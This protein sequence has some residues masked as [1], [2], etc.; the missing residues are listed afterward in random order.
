MGTALLAS[1]LLAPYGNER[2]IFKDSQKELDTLIKYLKKL[3]AKDDYVRGFEDAR[4]IMIDICLSVKKKLAVGNLYLNLLIERSKH[5]NEFKWTENITII[6]DEF[7]CITLKNGIR[8]AN[9]S[10]AHGYS[11]V[12]EEYLPS[13][14]KEVA[15]KYKM[16]DKHLEKTC[17]SQ[18]TGVAWQ[19]MHLVY[20]ITDE[21]KEALNDIATAEN[22]FVDVIL[23]PYPVIDTIKRENLGTASQ[24]GGGVLLKQEAYDKIRTCKKVDPRDV[25]AG[26]FSDKFCR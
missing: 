15:D 20:S 12:T 3:K 21:I 8:V 23:V 2:C 24:N 6:G 17:L 9:F 22:G 13:C 18:N 7:P 16:A 26:I 1:L 25:R 5:M 10:S 11:F 4:Q 14:T 19:D